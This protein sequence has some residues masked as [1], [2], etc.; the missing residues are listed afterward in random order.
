MD[1]SSDK[2]NEAVPRK[3]GDI[4]QIVFV[5]LLIVVIFAVCVQCC[6]YTDS[7][8][9]AFYNC[10]LPAYLNKMQ[11]VYASMQYFKNSFILLQFSVQLLVQLFPTTGNYDCHE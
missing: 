8:S 10:N 6:R 3:E 9:Y 5:C 7:R 2:L 4:A 1:L 11:F